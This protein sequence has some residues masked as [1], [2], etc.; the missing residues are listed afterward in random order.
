M[1]SS[2]I[3]I[4]QDGSDLGGLTLEN[5]WTIKAL[6]VELTQV[7][8]VPQPYTLGTISLLWHMLEVALGKVPR[9]PSGSPLNVILKRYEVMGLHQLSHIYLFSHIT[10]WLIK[11]VLSIIKVSACPMITYLLEPFAFF[12]NSRRL[13]GNDFLKLGFLKNETFPEHKVIN[14]GK[15]N[16][17]LA[18]ESSSSCRCSFASC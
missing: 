17:L 15:V 4:A 18:L 12:F 5:C 9:F 6:C 8:F 2:L 10:F 7:R 11:I 13:L 3:S 1:R 14:K 16:A